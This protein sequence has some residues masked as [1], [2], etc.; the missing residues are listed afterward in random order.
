[1]SAMWGYTGL[2]ADIRVRRDYRPVSQQFAQ[3]GCGAKRQSLA[4]HVMSALNE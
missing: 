1:M 2:D 3:Q 4:L